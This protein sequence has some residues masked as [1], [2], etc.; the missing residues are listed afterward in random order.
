MA[1]PIFVV[2]SHDYTAYLA[3]DGLQPSRNDLDAEGSGRNVLDGQMYRSRI[4]TK[5]KWTVLF[6][7][8]PAS[9]AAQLLTDMDAEY[10]NVTLLNPKTNTQTQKTYYCST[11]TSGYQRCRGGDTV[12]DGITFNL[13]ER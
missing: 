2:N 11:I 13:T 6:G 12:Y 10:V 4:A 9:T 5:D 3:D 1:K 8:M 7:R